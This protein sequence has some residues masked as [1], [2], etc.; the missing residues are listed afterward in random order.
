MFVNLSCAVRGASFWCRTPPEPYP[1]ADANFRFGPARRL[2]ISRV[3]HP[4]AFTVVLQQNAGTVGGLR[5]KVE[6]EGNEHHEE[7]TDSDPQKFFVLF[8]VSIMEPTTF[9]PRPRFPP[10]RAR[11]RRWRRHP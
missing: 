6:I 3:E 4:N 10:R 2:P 5:G 7:N 1:Q 9:S 11:A 8:V